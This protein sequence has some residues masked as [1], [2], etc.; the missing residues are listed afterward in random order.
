MANPANVAELLVSAS[1]TKYKLQVMITRSQTFGV[2]R[3]YFIYL[4]SDAAKMVL[5]LNEKVL[6]CIKYISLFSMVQEYETHQMV[7]AEG[8][9]IMMCRLKL[10]DTIASI[11]VLR[12]QLGRSVLKG[13]K[14]P[15]KNCLEYVFCTNVIVF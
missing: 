14:I 13:S 3:Y 6:F 15:L 12:L 8:S 5:L 10:M 7:L 4:S 1:L 11:P 2:K 9:C